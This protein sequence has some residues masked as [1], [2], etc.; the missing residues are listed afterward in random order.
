MQYGM[1]KFRIYQLLVID[2]GQFINISCEKHK[3]IKIKAY[4]ED[5]TCYKPILM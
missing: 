4:N 3:T 1:L 2:T 5:T